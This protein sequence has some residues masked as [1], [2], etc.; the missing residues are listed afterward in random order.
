MSGGYFLPILWL[1]RH[2]LGSTIYLDSKTIQ[3]DSIRTITQQAETDGF[4][5]LWLSDNFFEREPGES[6]R[7]TWE[8]W[9]MLSALAEATERVE[10][11]TLILC[12]AF[13]NPAIL[14]KMATTAD[15]VSHGR[16]I[17]GLGVTPTN[18]TL[19]PN[20]GVIS[21]CA[22]FNCTCLGR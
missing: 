21:S 4:D 6:T 9:T 3:Y 20:S 1:L 2:L 18:R 12:N 14:A 19:D 8:C 10:I 22:P 16:L 13:R 17:L 11:G 5:S 7:G 15:E